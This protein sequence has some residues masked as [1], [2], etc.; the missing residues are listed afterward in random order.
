MLGLTLICARKKPFIFPKDDT[1]HSVYDT[2]AKHNSRDEIKSSDSSAKIRIFVLRLLHVFN[3]NS[4]TYF[5]NRVGFIKHKIID[6]NK[7]I[8]MLSVLVRF[9]LVYAD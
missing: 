8:S 1:F 9:G 4:D 6:E 3:Y 7:T 5:I 2:F